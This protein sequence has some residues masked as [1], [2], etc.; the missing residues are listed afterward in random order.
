MFVRLQVHYTKPVELLNVGRMG[1]FDLTRDK[2][3]GRKHAPQK[4]LL[5]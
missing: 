5:F 3:L 1:N 2:S 4:R